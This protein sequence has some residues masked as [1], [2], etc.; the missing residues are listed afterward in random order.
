MKIARIETVVLKIPYTTGGSDEA[1]AWGGRP[2]TTAD[3]L[4]VRVETDNG[5]VGWGEAFGYNVIPATQ[6]VI[7]H[8]LTPMVVGAQ[9]DAIEP[10]M[11]EAEQKLHIFGRGGPVIYALSGLDIA[12]W[13]IAGKAAGVPVHRLLGGKAHDTLPCYASLIRYA[14]PQGV[15]A[16][17]QRARNAGFADIKLHEIDVDCIRAARQAA[18]PQARLMLDVNCPWTL[19]EALRVARVL[20]EVDPF[21]LEEPVWPPEDD[22]ALARI[23]RECG[24]PIAAGENAATPHQFAQLLRSGAVDILQ[25][26]PAKCGGISTLRK[27]FALADEYNARVVPHTF[28]DGPGLLAGLHCAA[29][30]QR[31]PFIEWRFFDVEAPVYKGRCMPAGGRIS[32]PDGPGLG[33]DPDPDVLKEFGTR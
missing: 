24:I 33:A 8:V 22:A 25:P 21:W 14:T 26:S 7:E 32:V 4:L 29:V 27:V 1:S 11:R 2:W 6:A 12:L 23:R 18:G 9:A 10:L 17:V 13:D 28:Y 15:A 19:S 31:E 20:R 3:S 16:N 30:F 5:I